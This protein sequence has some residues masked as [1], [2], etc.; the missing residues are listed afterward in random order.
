MTGIQICRHVSEKFADQGN[1][2]LLGAGALERASI[3]QWLKAEVQRFE[4]PS[5]ALV[6]HLAFAPVLN[7]ENVEWQTID[8]QKEKLSAVLDV[9][10]KRLSM[11]EYL[12][13]DKFTLAD[14]SHLPNTHYLWNKTTEGRRL[15]ESRKNVKRWW[16]LISKRPTWEKVVRMQREHPGPLEGLGPLTSTN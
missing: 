9:Y 13:G 5:S 7:P 1:K 4:P 2:D 15:F 12:A 6:F 8:D 11:S 3:E 10:D 14:L 16:E